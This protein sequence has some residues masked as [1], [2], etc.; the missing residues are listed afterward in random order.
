MPLWAAE[1]VPALLMPPP[2][3]FVFA[4]AIT[5][6]VAPPLATILLLLSTLMP[7]ETMPLSKMPPPLMNAPLISTMP[8]APIVPVLL[9]PP[10]K[11]VW[12]TRIWLVAPLNTTGNGPG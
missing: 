7:P 3:V 4:M 10:L 9:T 5:V 12:L 6:R 11:V 1:I 8:P 2:N